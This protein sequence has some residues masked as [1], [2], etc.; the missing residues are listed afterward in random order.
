M[1]FIELAE[2][3]YSVRKYDSRPIDRAV[4]D[5]CIEAARLAPSAVNAQPWHFVVADDPE[6]V[7]ALG[8]AASP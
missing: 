6:T 8:R 7:R 3:R 2:K 4:L 5:R 1:K